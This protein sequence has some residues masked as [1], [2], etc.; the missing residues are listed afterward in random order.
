MPNDIAEKRAWILGLT[1]DCPFSSPLS[2]CVIN[3]FRVVPLAE[4][5]KLLQELPASE[6]EHI[7]QYHKECFAEREQGL[8]LSSATSQGGLRVI[9]RD[10][11]H[12]FEN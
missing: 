2:D 11:R 9:S 12:T 3:Q 10:R 1:V 7:Y 5:H 8:L 4:A 6:L